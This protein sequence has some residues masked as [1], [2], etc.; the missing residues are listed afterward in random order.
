MITIQNLIKTYKGN[1]HALQGINL[2][3]GHGMFGLLGPNGA[4]KTTLMRIIAG[5]L[6]PSE[7]TVTVMGHDVSETKGRLEVKRYLGYLPQE[8]GLYP[9]LSAWEFLDYMGILKGITDTPARK[10][11]VEELLHLVRLTDT[12]KRPLKA[13]SGGMKRRIGIAQAML[14]DP[15]LLIVDEPTVGLDPEERV[16]IRNILSEMASHRTVILS[17]H[18]IEDIGHS[19][20]DLA[21]INKGNVMFRGA[22]ADLIDEAQG[23]VWSI[24]SQHDYPD[25]TLQ[26]VSMI[27]M[28]DEMQFRVLGK[29]ADHYSAIAMEP[30]LEDGYMLKMRKA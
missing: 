24:R 8:L 10:A 30:S 13:F 6:R 12:G 28:R 2:E 22:P 19:C 11:Q 9:N 14:G 7:G 23:Q 3:I 15:K 5:L 18:V 17:T 16:H 20:N 27:Q 26:V 21:I 29:P 4:G 1:V 25:P